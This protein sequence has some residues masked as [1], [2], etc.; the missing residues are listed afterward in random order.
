MNDPIPYKET[1]RS[2]Y[3]F[4]G[5]SELF[6]TPQNLFAKLNGKHLQN[7]R[8]KWFLFGVSMVTLMLKERV[9]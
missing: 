5:C 9:I 7:L 4:I 8:E 3:I 2:S 1:S 6:T